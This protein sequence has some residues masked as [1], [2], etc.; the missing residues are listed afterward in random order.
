MNKLEIPKIAI[1]VLK[2]DGEIKITSEKFF[3]SHLSSF[4]VLYSVFP[5][6]YE[7]TDTCTNSHMKK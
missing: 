7:K 1:K 6:H 2:N 5:F 4:S 3:P